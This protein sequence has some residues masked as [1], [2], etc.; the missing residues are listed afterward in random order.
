MQGD[1]SGERIVLIL[2][3][4]NDWYR[5]G[6]NEDPGNRTETTDKL[7]H[8]GG[9]VHVVPHSC[10]GHQT[11]P[12]RLNKSPTVIPI[13]SPRDLQRRN[14]IIFFSAKCFIA[15]GYLKKCKL[16]KLMRFLIRGHS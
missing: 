3:R 16:F 8:E 2:P 7:A 12:E 5:E 15:D 4:D 10:Q 1:E 6:Q 14:F 11:P 13:E 9:G